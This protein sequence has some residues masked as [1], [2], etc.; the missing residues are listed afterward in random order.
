MGPPGECVCAPQWAGTV[1]YSRFKTERKLTGC[2]PQAAGNREL[3]QF[4]D[5]ALGDFITDGWFESV[6]QPLLGPNVSVD[7]PCTSFPAY[8]SRQSLTPNGRCLR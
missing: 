6:W 3:T 7:L 2:R 8:P 5:A 4:L 1:S